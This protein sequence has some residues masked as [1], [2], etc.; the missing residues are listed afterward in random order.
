[1]VFLTK[2][3]QSDQSTFI[4]DSDEIEFRYDEDTSVLESCSLV[5]ENRMFILGGVYDEGRVPR[6]AHLK[7]DL[8]V[9]LKTGTNQYFEKQISEVTKCS[10][11]KKSELPF[12]FTN[13]GCSNLNNHEV[14]LCFSFDSPK[15]FFQFS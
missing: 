5:I 9:Y 14:L 3:D 6:N 1:M 13:G 12:R 2:R 15:E 11:T 7:A 4:G 10:L 8:F